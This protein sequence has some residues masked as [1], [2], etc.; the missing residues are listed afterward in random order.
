MN[1]GMRLQLD[2]LKIAFVWQTPTTISQN[3]FAHLLL[4][5]IPSFV[6]IFE[7]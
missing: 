6:S 2:L 7:L 3:N 1:P 4:L 5:V